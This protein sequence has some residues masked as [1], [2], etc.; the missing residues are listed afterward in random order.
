[1]PPSRSLNPPLFESWLTPGLIEPTRFHEIWNFK[2]QYK[3]KIHIKI[4]SFRTTQRPPFI[5][6]FLIYNSSSRQHEPK[7]Q[8]YIPQSFQQR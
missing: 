5:M 1:M 2:A 7:L 6:T 4:L 8:N 3:R